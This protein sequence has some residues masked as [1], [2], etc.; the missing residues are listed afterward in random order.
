MNTESVG[1]GMPGAKVPIYELAKELGMPNKDL[2]D[3]IRALGIDAKNHMSRLEPED[4]A[5]AIVRSCRTRPGEV[6]VPGFLRAMPVI[7]SALP[8]WP[9]RMFRKLVQQERVLTDAKQAARAAYEGDI[10]AQGRE[11]GAAPAGDLGEVVLLADGERGVGAEA[12]LVERGDPGA[13]LV[14]GADDVRRA[15]LVLVL[16]AGGGVGRDLAARRHAVKQA[17]TH[18]AR[19]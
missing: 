11:A 15:A 4:V 7:E 9:V 2:V 10:R 1:T 13:R 6:S 3:K 19:A 14:H 12:A 18:R 8:A 16:R 17:N 5:R